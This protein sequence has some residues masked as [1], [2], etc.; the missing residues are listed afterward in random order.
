MKRLYT[1]PIPTTTFNDLIMLTA[2]HLHT[3]VIHFPIALLMVGF[4]SELIRLF[5]K[6]EFFKTVALFA[7]ISL[8][9]LRVAAI[10]GL[11]LTFRK[12]P[13]T[14]TVAFVILFISLISFG[15]V[16][17]TGYLGGQIRHTEINSNVNPNSIQNDKEVDSD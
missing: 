5:S 4:I 13:F 11:F 8:I 10:L 14:R 12:S 17:R 7:L 1:V 9:I 3:M 2:P 16:A 6:K 15:L